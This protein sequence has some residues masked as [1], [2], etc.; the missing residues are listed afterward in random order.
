MKHS[1]FFQSFL[2][3]SFVICGYS[4]P[5][6]PKYERE[7]FLKQD[8]I[9]SQAI[10]FIREVFKNERIQWYGE[11]N[12]RGTSIEAKLKSGGQSY[13]I[14]FSNSGLIQDVEILTKFSSL[15]SET[16]SAINE[17]LKKD[18]RSYKISK[19]QTQWTGTKQALKDALI[20]APAKDG[21]NPDGISIKYELIVRAKKAGASGYYEVL[22]NKAGQVQTI[23]QIVQRNTD[24]LIY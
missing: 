15:P 22:T 20:N 2:I 3:T 23:R 12:L 10:A 4:A 9:P 18:F 16:R 6:Q 17:R 13:S 14:E 8:A 11:E 5:A 19:T 21:K 1:A 24:N 7:Y